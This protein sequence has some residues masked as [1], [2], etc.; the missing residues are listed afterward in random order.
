MSIF[1]PINSLLKIYNL[2]HLKPYQIFVCVSDFKL[3]TSSV[4]ISVL[5]KLL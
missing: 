2:K 1:K 5:Q 3:P 4:N